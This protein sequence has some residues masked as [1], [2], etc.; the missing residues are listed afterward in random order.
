MSSPI[1]LLAVFLENKPGQAALVSEILAEAG[2]NLFW[3]TMANNGTFGV[4]KFLVDKCDLAVQELKK[5][6]LLVSQLPVL[7]VEAD[8]RPGALLRVTASLRTQNINLDN[9]SGF[10]A[11]DHAVLLVEVPDIA[12]AQA[13][14]EGQGFRLLT[15]DQV[16]RL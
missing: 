7:A 14:L 10:V 15:Q 4:M 12:Q 16:L 2:V 1:H 13:T 5:K 9:C 6:G 8:N 11:R 3:L